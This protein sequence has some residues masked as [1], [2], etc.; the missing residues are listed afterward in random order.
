L[1]VFAP[2]CA[3]AKIGIGPGET[4]PGTGL[5]R[6]L[7]IFLAMSAIAL[8]ITEACLLVTHYGLGLTS[9]VDD[10]LSAN[11]LGLALATAW[12]F[13]SFRK[14]VFLQPATVDGE[15]QLAA[16]GRLGYARL[17]PR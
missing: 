8:G 3:A 7:T 16:T 4:A 10:N 5:T 2:S 1:R 12:R 15:Q 9:K 17:G 14:W 6:E 13:W 11:A